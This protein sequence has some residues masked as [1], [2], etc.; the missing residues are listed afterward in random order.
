M[1]SLKRVK[2]CGSDRTQDTESGLMAIG[3]QAV[4]SKTI[5]TWLSFFE[6]LQTNSD[7]AIS[8]RMKPQLFYEF[9]WPSNHAKSNILCV[10]FNPHPYRHGRLQRGAIS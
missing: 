3:K 1:L 9:A 7:N 6:P 5:G 8:G 4:S 2:T 10:L